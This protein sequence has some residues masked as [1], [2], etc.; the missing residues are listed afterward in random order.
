MSL[1]WLRSYSLVACCKDP[2]CTQE[3]GG[4]EGGRE[5]GR[6]WIEKEGGPMVKGRR[7]RNDGER[8]GE[9]VERGKDVTVCISS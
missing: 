4:R 2:F 7:R 5:E 9:D 6:G 1:E 3:K 8:E